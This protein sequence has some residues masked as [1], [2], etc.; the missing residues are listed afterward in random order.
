MAFQSH[1]G[2]PAALAPMRTCPAPKPFG[3]PCGHRLEEGSEVCRA[4]EGTER[5][6]QCEAEPFVRH[7]ARVR[8][9]SWPLSDLPFCGAH[10]P[11]TITLRREEQQSVRARV[12]R[13]R[14][15]IATAPVLIRERVLDLLV[16]ERRVDVA[17]VEATLRSYRL[18]G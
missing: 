5:G 7:G 3:R 6:R 16:A 12:T 10:D 17:A 2:K 14:E 8:C 1:G 9:A 18:L 15:A 11:V 13:V 4:H